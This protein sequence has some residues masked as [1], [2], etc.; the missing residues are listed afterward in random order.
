MYIHPGGR[1]YNTASVVPTAWAGAGREKK[2]QPN[3]P[4]QRIHLVIA[5]ANG[6]DYDGV[7]SV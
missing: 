1:C 7:Y 2:I 4:A 3:N 5:A 6:R